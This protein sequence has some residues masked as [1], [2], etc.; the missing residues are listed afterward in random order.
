MSNKQRFHEA[1][2]DMAAAKALEEENGALKAKIAELEQSLSIE[3]SKNLGFESALDEANTKIAEL[4]QSIA[5]F[6]TSTAELEKRIEEEKSSI[7][8]YE[9]LRNLYHKKVQDF[10]DGLEEKEQ[11]YAREDALKRYN[12]EKEIQKSQQESKLVIAN[13]IEEFNSSFNYYLGHIRSL[14]DTII[15]SAAQ[16]GQNLFVE[17]DG[18]HNYKHMIGEKIT[19]VL[20]NIYGDLMKEDKPAEDAEGTD[21]AEG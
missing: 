2:A 9:G 20:E 4:E 7:A 6:H 15:D 14:M 5:A 3:K 13:T 19:E 11:A 17:G 1:N 10:T 16:S 21:G 8:A 18:D 12:L